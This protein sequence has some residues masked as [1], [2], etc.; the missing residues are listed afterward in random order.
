M[1]ELLEKNSFD[2]ISELVYS[3]VKKKPLNPFMD[4]NKDWNNR[5]P[6]D[7]T[8]ELT[9]LLKKEIIRQDELFGDFNLLAKSIKKTN[10]EVQNELIQQNKMLKRLDKDVF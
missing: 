1:D 7:N 9:S 5:N 4:S 10:L 2:K 8:N 3:P 6:N